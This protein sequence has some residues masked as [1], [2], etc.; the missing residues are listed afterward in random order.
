MIVEVDLY[1]VSLTLRGETILS[2]CE[3][4]IASPFPFSYP[5]EMIKSR[6]S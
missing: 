1:A 2:F 3:S 6:L 4:L 5:L